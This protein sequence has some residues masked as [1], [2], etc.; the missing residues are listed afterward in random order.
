MR[1]IYDGYVTVRQSGESYF[2]GANTGRGFRGSYD[3]IAPEGEIERLY[4]IKGG[5]GT[6]KSTLMKKAAAEAE[7]RGLPVRYYFCGSDPDS[8]DAVV[9]DGRIAVLD[10]T[11]PHVVDMKY[12]GACSSLIDVSRFWNAEELEENKEEIIALAKRK[13]ERYRSAYRYLAAAE[14]LEGEMTETLLHALDLAKLRA[15]VAR[16]AKALGGKESKRELRGPAREDSFYTCGVTMK[17][18]AAFE[19]LLDKA[20]TVISVNDV[21]G[22]ASLLLEELGKA[23]LNLGLAV[24]VAKIPVN[25]RRCGLYV[26]EVG[27]AFAVNRDGG[28]NGGEKCVNMSRFLEKEPFEQCRGRLKFTQKCVNAMLDEAA[29]LLME[30]GES[31]FALEKLYIGSMDFKALNRYA[32][33]VIA[34]IVERLQP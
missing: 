25:D 34:E 17:G 2:A 22:S 31:H 12:P 11:A 10:G 13:S 14:T 24:E 28:E 16:T 5:S 15:Y 7:K 18:L 32:N 33:A 6:G 20:E 19:P 21:F 23:F 26:P 30:A 9:L 4:I 29:E 3:V 8:L 27:C 1:G